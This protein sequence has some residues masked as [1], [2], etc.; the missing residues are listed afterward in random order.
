M[1]HEFKSQCLK[2]DCAL[3]SL[4]KGEFVTKNESSNIPVKKEPE[5]P[6]NVSEVPLDFEDIKREDIQYLEDLSGSD[7]EALCIIQSTEEDNKDC[8]ESIEKNLLITKNAINNT[9]KEKKPKSHVCSFCLKKFRNSKAVKSHVARIHGAATHPH[10]CTQCKDSFETGHDLELHAPIHAPGPV[11][12][13]VACDKWFKGRSMFRR[14]IL[15]HM[16]CKR[17]ACESCGKPFTELYALRRHARVHTGEKVEKRHAC[18]LCEKRYTHS[19][20]LEAHLARHGDVRPCVCS[21]CGKAFPSTRLLLSHQRIHLDD[22]PHACRYC[23][24][25]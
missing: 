15:R 19:S 1:C 11:W 5:Q 25:R 2:S 20:L 4:L 12:T 17:Y 14:H 18:H 22:K 7:S 23:D 16:E 21:V 24:K 6:A 8:I 13:C 3:K 9:T 10:S